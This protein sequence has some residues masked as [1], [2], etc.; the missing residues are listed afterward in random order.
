MKYKLTYKCRLC[1][2]EFQSHGT[3]E[4]FGMPIGELLEL[5]AKNCKKHDKGVPP[6]HTCDNGDIGFG[7]LIGC[8]KVEE[9]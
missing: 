9:D 3:F 6:H 1:G 5:Y 7:E 4:T 2:E 8:R